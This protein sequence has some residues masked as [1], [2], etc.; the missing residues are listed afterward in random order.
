[1]MHMQKKSSKQIVKILVKTFNLNIS[2]TLV[3]ELVNNDRAM[4]I[5]S[6]VTDRNID[7]HAGYNSNSRLS[8]TQ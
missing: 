1:M 3:K 5:F 4:A 6:D 2:Q 7:T 8:L